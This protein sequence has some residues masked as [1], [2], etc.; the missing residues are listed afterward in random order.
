[1]VRALVTRD[2]VHAF[3]THVERSPLFGE[4]VRVAV[5]VAMSSRP[6]EFVPG[7]DLAM[8]GNDFTGRVISCGRAVDRWR[9]GDRVCGSMRAGAFA[10]EI[11]VPAIGLVTVRPT[12]RADLVS[13]IP[14]SGLAA[15]GVAESF[16]LEPGSLALV[17]AAGGAFS[18]M[19]AGLLRSAGVIPIATCAHASMAPAL[20]SVGYEAV[21]PGAP[22]P[23]P[24]AVREVT[25]GRPLDAVFDLEPTGTDDYS[26]LDLSPLAPV[27][28]A[29]AS[30]NRQ[31]TAARD[32]DAG[33]WLT[34]WLAAD[35]D[36]LRSAGLVLFD[37][38]TD[39]EVRVPIESYS[40]ADGA[41]AWERICSG[42][43]V[44]RI[45]GRP[46]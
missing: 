36:R 17:S 46:G 6:V 21:I 26:L 27:V 42:N 12:A 22:C 13:L 1:M 29:R 39:G 10:D 16:P 14:T 28:R 30:L 18:C 4:H 15:M 32:R 9:P 5:E 40:L 44:G 45:A 24:D 41:A 8:L 20:L 34:N 37:M 2:G 35:P 43:V 38:L 23:A 19:F 33:F 11:V 25:A 7:S 3:V 31:F